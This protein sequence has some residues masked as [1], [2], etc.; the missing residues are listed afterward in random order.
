MPTVDSI[1]AKIANMGKE[2]ALGNASLAG[3][4][5]NPLPFPEFNDVPVQRSA[6]ADRFD[7][8]AARMPE[9]LKGG[10]LADVGAHVGY[11]CFMFNR[12][13][14][15]KCVGIE[16]HALTAQIGNDC[17]KLYGVDVQI[18]TRSITPE[19]FHDKEFD[20]C[21]FL[22][23]FQWITKAEGFEYACE[24]LKEALAAS[25]VLFFE[26]SMGNEG[27]A[28][29]PMLPNL[30]AVFQM[31]VNLGAKPVC[32]GPVVSPGGANDQRRYLFQC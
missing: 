6:C 20:V 18:E 19:W 8:M 21:L 1:K 24:T 9:H 26:T 27:K 28:K 2:Y 14:N 22:S 23:V 7:M 13:F 12:Y 5:Y 29:M 16:A 25:K 11:N 3:H 4:L 32:L 15:M 10:T 17:A 30:D 31:L